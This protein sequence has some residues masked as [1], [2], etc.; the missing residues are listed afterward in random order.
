MI[1]CRSVPDGVSSMLSEQD[2][3]AAPALF[4]LK[5]DE[6]VVG[7]V[8]R[9][10]V[11]FVDDYASD[12]LAGDKVSIYL[13]AGRSAVLADSPRSTNSRMTVAS[14]DCALRRQASRC[15]GIE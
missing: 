9:K 15:A 12:R 11:H 3:S 10:A 8:A 4:D 2:T 14:R 5:T 6:H 7:P 1:P 13:S